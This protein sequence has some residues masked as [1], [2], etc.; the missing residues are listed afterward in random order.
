MDQLKK[1]EIVIAKRGRGRPAKPKAPVDDAI[2][3]VRK[4]R[5][6]KPTPKGPVLLKTVPMKKELLENKVFFFLTWVFIF[7]MF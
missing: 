5:G 2:P 7:L 6:C 4:P 1:I 3:V